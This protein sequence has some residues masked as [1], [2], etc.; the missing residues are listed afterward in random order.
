[1]NPLHRKRT[2]KKQAPGY[3]LIDLQSVKSTV[4]NDELG[5]DR[6]KKTKG[7]KR[8]IVVDALCNLIQVKVHAV[9]LH[10]AKAGCDV[11]RAVS[12]KYA[13]LKALSED[14]G[15]RGSVVKCV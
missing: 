7:R 6:G 13:T 4:A 1:M 9:N 12:E 14:F 8:H 5:F 15:Y 3:G 11:L 10:D 2:L